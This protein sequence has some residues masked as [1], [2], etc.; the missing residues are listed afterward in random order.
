MHFFFALLSYSNDPNKNQNELN[1]RT[2]IVFFFS[3]ETN[4]YVSI[5]RINEFDELFRSDSLLYVLKKKFCPCSHRIPLW[6][7]FCFFTVSTCRVIQC[8]NRF[9]TICSSV[10]IRVTA[11][12]WIPYMMSSHVNW[13]SSFYYILCHR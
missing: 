8:Q 7:S 13:F 4:T 12:S 6:I 3:I 9:K 10:V 5:M 2:I 1:E 11:W